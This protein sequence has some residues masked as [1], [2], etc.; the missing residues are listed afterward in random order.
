MIGGHAIFCHELSAKQADLGH[1]VRVFTTRKKGEPDYQ[2]VKRGYEITR[3]NRV[4]MPWDSMRMSNPV[5]PSL[6]GAIRNQKWD[7]IDAHS[8]LFWMTAL[9]VKAALDSRVPAIMTVH[10]FLAL[11]DCLTNL[12]QKAYLRSVGV[13][14][15]RNSS[16]VICLTKSDAQEAIRLGVAGRK[17]SV[18]PVAVDL[19]TFRPYGDKRNSIVWIGRLVPEK[20]LETLLRALI[21]LRGKAI[22]RVVIVGDGPLRNRLISQAHALGISDIV[23]FRLKMDRYDVSKLLQESR[24]FVLPSVREGLPMTLLEAMASGNT[25]V[26]SDLPPIREIL[27]DAGLYF[28]PGKSYELANAL[29]QALNDKGLQREKG[30][31]AREIVEKR[32]GWNVVLPKLEELYKEIIAEHG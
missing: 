9:S 21:M 19:E 20:G 15:L 12:S 23:T 14:A 31:G 18:I 1:R 25:I 10:G 27:G 22:T 11:R 13:W 16:R 6:Y 7:L 5:T 29:M 3:L 2:S 30:R 4:W 8:P 26:T 17:I 28:T 32:F 24:V